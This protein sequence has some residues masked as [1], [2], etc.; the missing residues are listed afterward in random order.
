MAKNLNK[1]IDIY[2]VV[3]IQN[4]LKNFKSMNPPK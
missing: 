4:A 2:N 1:V 3:F